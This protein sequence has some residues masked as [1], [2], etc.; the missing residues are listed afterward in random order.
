MFR[1]SSVEDTWELDCR[2]SLPVVSGVN[3]ACMVSFPARALYDQGL[4]NAFAL[5]SHVRE[6]RL[7]PHRI[8]S[9]FSSVRAEPRLP[10]VWEVGLLASGAQAAL[11]SNYEV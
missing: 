10:L 4:S 1:H 9:A 5:P 8:N 2:I 7:A 6:S 3:L 11:F